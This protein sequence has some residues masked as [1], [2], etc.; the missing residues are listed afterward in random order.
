MIDEDRD[1]DDRA[2]LEA[3]AGRG[4]SDSP[5]A[6]EARELRAGLRARVAER[7]PAVP[8]EDP[9][10]EEELIERAR[11]A[12]LVPARTAVR[13]RVAEGSPWW[14]SW[15][16]AAAAAVA[17][18]SLVTIGVFTLRPS[19]EPETVREAQDGIVRLESSDPSGLKGLLLEELRRAGVEATGYETLGRQGID[20][21]LPEPLPPAVRRILE[22][23][24]IP[25]PR[26]GVLRVE[27]VRRERD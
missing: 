21:D 22:N 24:E 6:A 1:E 20:A 11:H 26:D 16:G 13:A 27:I 7:E 9:A 4:A 14:W 3:L 17:C 15:R 12:G 25:L 2:W 18:A 10:R 19:P 23:H 8:A 5:A